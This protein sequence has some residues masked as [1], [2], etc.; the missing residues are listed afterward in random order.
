M[1]IDFSKFPCIANDD[2]ED[3]IEFFMETNSEFRKRDNTINSIRNPSM[4]HKTS[5]VSLRIIEKIF[6]LQ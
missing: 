4:I 1:G 3:M 5:R 2:F 6:N